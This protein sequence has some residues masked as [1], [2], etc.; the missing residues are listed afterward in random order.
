MSSKHRFL[1]F[2]L[3][4]GLFLCPWT[5]DA[6]TDEK[7]KKKPEPKENVF[8]VENTAFEGPFRLPKSSDA[9][10]ELS[11]PYYRAYSDRGMHHIF[12]GDRWIIGIRRSYQY[13]P[14]VHGSWYENITLLMPGKLEKDQKEK[15]Y[16][17]PEVLA[18]YSVIGGFR[19]GKLAV[20]EK[21]TVH[22]YPYDAGHLKIELDLVFRRIEVDRKIGDDDLELSVNEGFST[23]VPSN[24]KPFSLKKTF[25]AKKL[26][27]K[28]LDSTQRGWMTKE[29]EDELWA[30]PQE[31]H[32]NQTN[33]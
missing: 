20:A 19:W 28:Q 5:S 4:I 24:F 12:E 1:L 27:F 26:L 17:A 23:N 16:E 3:G 11:K 2:F 13:T 7:P 25:I 14:G 18:Y 33:K 6:Q 9:P 15:V 30:S 22:I 31:L 10:I 8:S 21:G 32:G 29:E